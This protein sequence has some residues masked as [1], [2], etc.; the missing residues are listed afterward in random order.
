MSIV[1]CNHWLEKKDK[2]LNKAPSSSIQSALEEEEADFTVRTEKQAPD[3]N[4]EPDI[5]VTS[6]D[7]VAVC[8][9][10]TW[11][12]TGEKVEGELE[13]RQSTLTVG[14]VQKYMLEKVLEY[15]KDLGF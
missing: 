1:G 2:Q 8:I 11:R 10:A 5:L 9:E 3:S 14:H 13:S 15:V 7:G 6:E 4:L 12:S